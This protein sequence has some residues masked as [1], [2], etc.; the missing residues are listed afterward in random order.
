MGGVACVARTLLQA[1]KNGSSERLLVDR[2][3]AGLAQHHSERRFGEQDLLTWRSRFNPHH[4]A[5]PG[6]EAFAG[7]VHE[8]TRRAH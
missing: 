1:G 5:H 3:R 6:P 4:F 2:A 7:P 8:M